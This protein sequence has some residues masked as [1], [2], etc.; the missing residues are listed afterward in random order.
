MNA[1]LA[2]FA[3]QFE[4]R[5]VNFPSTTANVSRL[6]Y[7]LVRLTRPRLILEMGFHVGASTAW[8]ATAIRE[9]GAGLLVAYDTDVECFRACAANLG[10][11]IG[12]QGVSLI[13]DD[14]VRSLR[15][16]HATADFVFIDI[17]PKSDYE[18]AF[19]ALRTPVGG[20]VCAHDLMLMRESD[21]PG[22]SQNDGP[23]R[24]HDRLKADPAWEVLGLPQERGL[25]VARRVV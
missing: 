23:Q 11:L 9:N 10:N 1:A 12:M 4:H 17:E 13:N 18:A 15:A 19:A 8:L 5:G 25:M 3:T 20:I 22:A 6:L 2:G 24:L 14:A 7:A 16:E 21:D